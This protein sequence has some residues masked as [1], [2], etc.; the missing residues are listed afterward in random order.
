MEAANKKLFELLKQ[1]VSDT[2]LK[3]NH[4]P[5]A[6]GDWKGEEIERFQEDLFVH[7]RGRVSEKWF[8]TYFKNEAEKLPRIDMLNLLS[9]YAGYENWN[10]FRSK[11]GELLALE[12]NPKRKNNKFLWLFLPVLPILIAMYFLLNS[13]N[14]FRFCMIDEDRGE[15][16]TQ[17][18]LDVKILSEGQSPIYLKTDSSGC[19]E[20]SSKEKIIRFVV[21]SPY[22]KT[23]TIIRHID[24]N[25][26]ANVPL[27]TDDYALMLRYYSNGN[28]GELQKRKQQLNNLIADDAQIYQIFP[29]QSGIELYS[30]EE[31]INKLTVPTSS[32]KNIN[33]L[34]KRY[35]DGKI[36]K[37]KFSIE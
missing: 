5:I 14:S 11:H 18:P 34:D 10:T 33:I 26:N 35:R 31:F 30:K 29:A 1:A 21:Q 22:H 15:P 17:I 36:V 25:E 3:E 12:E 16:I 27:A 7:T 2:F 23:D 6:I 28:L 32:L 4:A 20:Y 9:E 13:E 24:A 8:Y 37:L 19:F